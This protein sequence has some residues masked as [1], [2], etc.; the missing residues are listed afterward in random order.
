MPK[1]SIDDAGAHLS[2]FS[3]LVKAGSDDL[4]QGRFVE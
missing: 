3:A 4:N 1:R 2:R